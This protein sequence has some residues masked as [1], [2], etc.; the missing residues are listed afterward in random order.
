MIRAF[1][2]LPLPQPLEHRLS[3]LQDCLRDGHPVPV[4]NFHLTL[5]FLGEQSES[6]LDDLHVLLSAAVLPMP[7]LRLVGLSA[8]GGKKPRAFVARF[9]PEP[10]LMALQARVARLAHEVGIALEH[11]RFAPHVT[12]ARFAPGMVGAPQLAAAIAAAGLITSEDHAVAQMHLNRS[13]LLASGPAY[14][15]LASYALDG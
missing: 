14:E 12:L 5:A 9:A 6:V 10:R 11:R 15:V 2:S 13:R 1:L 3:L 4:E 8:F 7:V